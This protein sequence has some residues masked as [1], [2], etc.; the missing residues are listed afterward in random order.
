VATV[1][2]VERARGRGIG[3]ALVRTAVADIASRGLRD[4]ELSVDT[5]N[6]TGAIALYERAGLEVRR[7]IHIFERVLR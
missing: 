7:E 6:E 1:G 5:G 4:V 2:V 3:F